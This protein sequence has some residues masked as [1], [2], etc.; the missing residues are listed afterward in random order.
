MR[1]WLSHTAAVVLGMIGIPIAL[2]FL[3]IGFGLISR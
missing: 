1:R 2:I 3:G